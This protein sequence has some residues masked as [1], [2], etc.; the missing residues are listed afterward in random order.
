[1]DSI[2]LGHSLQPTEAP[3]PPTGSGLTKKQKIIAFIRKNKRLLLI[4]LGVLLLAGGGWWWVAA[5]KTPA[6]VVETPTPTPSPTPTP[7]TMPSLLNGAIVATE[8]YNRRPTAVMIENSPD[9]RPQRGLVNADVVYEAMVEGS[10]TRFMA[11]FQQDPPAKAGPIRSARSYY[12]D[13][14]SEYDAAYV[15]AGGSPTALDR[16]RSYGI[17]D[18]PHSTE[19]VFWREPKAGVASEH[20]LFGDIKTISQNAVSKKGWPATSDY[21]PWLFKDKADVPGSTGPI[22][23]N[24]GGAQFKVDWT[25][26][27]TTSDYSRSMAGAAHKDRDSGEQIKA[28]TIVVMTVERAA[29]APYKDTKK[30]SEWSMATIGSG[31]VSVFQDGGRIDGIWKK[32]SRTERTRFYDAASKEIE[33]NRGKI[34]VQVIPPTSTITVAA[35]P[36]V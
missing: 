15:H 7:A 9:A 8:I 24:Y 20:T 17:K 29:N 10:I 12:I 35:P 26:D 21:K 23:I 34:W 18:Y 14:L 13:W 19:S 4:A 6:V 33:L 30:E 32:T 5:T 2:N 27:K 16:I 11:V 28:R 3:T 1:M 31:P 25:F 22:S 36:A